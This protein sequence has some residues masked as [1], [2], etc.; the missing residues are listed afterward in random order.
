MPKGSLNVS[1]LDQEPPSLLE[2]PV[3]YLAVK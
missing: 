2:V 3:S 1:D